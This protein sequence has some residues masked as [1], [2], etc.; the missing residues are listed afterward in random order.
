MTH[1]RVENTEIS[2]TLWTTIENLSKNTI[3]NLKE[4]HQCS[5]NNNELPTMPLQ[6]SFQSELSIQSR[7]SVILE[8]AQVPQET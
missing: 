5:Q 7:Q 3:K 8:D 4:I 2:E 6:S 1:S